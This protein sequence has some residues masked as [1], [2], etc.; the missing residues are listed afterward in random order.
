MSEMT[1]LARARKIMEIDSSD[2]DHGRAA[3]EIYDHA[4]HLALHVLGPQW[5][6][7]GGSVTAEQQNE[8]RAKARGVVDELRSRRPAAFDEYTDRQLWQAALD[9][10][11]TYPDF[12]ALVFLHHIMN[13]TRPPECPYELHDPEP[14]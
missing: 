14:S 6:A 3:R 1:P 9:A 8:A 11:S 12:V 2:R 10:R 13:G 4:V 5:A 7:K